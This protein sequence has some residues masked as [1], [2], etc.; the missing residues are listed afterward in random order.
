MGTRFIIY[1]LSG[2]CVEI[3]WTGLGSLIKGDV[4]LIGWSSIWMVPIYGMLA[5]FEPVH[6]RIRYIPVVL[7]GGVYTTLI[8]A[9]EFLTGFL[10]RTILGKCPWNYGADKYSIDGLIT[11]KFIPAWFIFGLLFE[12]YHDF[13]IKK[14]VGTEGEYNK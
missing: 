2:L 9:G 1:G 7:R 12:V 3:L 5:L 6:N 11:L 10:L 4:T 13:L 14:G 8:F